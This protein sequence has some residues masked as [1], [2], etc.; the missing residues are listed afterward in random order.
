[1]VH[2]T[3]NEIKASY[4]TGAFLA[5]ATFSQVHN[6]HHTF[7][8]TCHDVM[9][10][11]LRVFFAASIGF[12]VPVTMLEEATVWKNG[13]AL[14]AT[15]VLIKL[16]VVA[17]VPAFEDSQKGAIYNPY[18]RDIV[19]TG[20]SMTCRGEFSFIIA[21]FGLQNKLL[22]EEMYG[23]IVLAV[24]LSA[25]T[26]PLCLMKS[27]AKFKDLQKEYLKSTNPTTADK[28]G[29]GKMPLFIKIHIETEGAWGLIDVIRTELHKLDLVIED[30]R[31]SHERGVNAIITNDI[32]ARVNEI[33]IAIP[34]VEMEKKK[35]TFA[36]RLNS[37]SDLINVVKELTTEDENNITYHED[38]DKSP[39]DSVHDKNDGTEQT[40]ER[41][42]LLSEREEINLVKD[43]IKL[44]AAVSNKVT[45]I[46]MTLKDSLAPFGI[47]TLHISRFNPWDWSAALDT[48]NMTRSNGTQPDLNFFMTLFD[49]FD[50]DDSGSLDSDELY[51]ALLNAGIAITREGLVAMIAAVDDNQDGE[52][53]REEWE[54]AITLYLQK[55]NDES[56]FHL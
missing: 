31:T 29:D 41:S 11:L 36:K 21:A 13:I 6:F 27:I 35:I 33:R 44:E 26:S 42:G 51:E 20:L 9:T 17:F 48:L 47:K 45:S 46:E 34:T 22:N 7:K 10:W 43:E 24:L 32:Y 52:I 3:Q 8:H 16:F 53:S 49:L 25:I 4:L 56:I 2:S 38:S 1:M 39:N 12:Q 18:R 54:N 19:V 40:S 28:E 50:V 23:S 14:W 55:K 37:Y 30:F 5:G 15:C